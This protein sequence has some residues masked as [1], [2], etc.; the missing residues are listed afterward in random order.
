MRL[1]GNAFV[2]MSLGSRWISHYL[3]LVLVLAPN[4]LLCKYTT[5]CTVAYETH[6]FTWFNKSFKHP[7]NSSRDKNS[8]VFAMQRCSYLHPCT[9]WCFPTL[10]AGISLGCSFYYLYTYICHCGLYFYF[11]LFT[12][13]RNKLGDAIWPFL[14]CFF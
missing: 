1:D 11:F 2:G 10:Q 9:T 6:T 13:W 4:Y 7:I 14:Y 5:Q 8:S 12:A 3:L